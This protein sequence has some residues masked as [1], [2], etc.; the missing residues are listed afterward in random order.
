MLVAS[1]L[2]A[3]G[4]LAGLLASSG[5][6]RHAPA[7]APTASSPSYRTTHVTQPGAT[8]PPPATTRPV[9]TSQPAA[10]APAAVG[11]VAITVADPRGAVPVQLYFPAARAGAA[12]VSPA[13]APYPLIVFSPGYDI[14]PAAYTPLMDAW[15]AARY[16][17]A[18][19]TY[20][21]TAPG[22]PN[23]LDEADIV[24]HPAD[25]H[26]VIDQILALSAAPGGLL[27]GMVDPGRLGVAGHSDG[28]DVTDAVVSNSCCRD[29]RIKAAAVLAG[30]ELTS[31]GGTY[32]APSVPL[33][34]AQGDADPINVPACSE[35]IY[36][37]A[38]APRYYLDLHGAQHHTPYMSAPYSGPPTAA[39]PEYRQAVVTVSVLFWQAYLRQDAAALSQLA[40]WSG[41]GSAATLYAG[42]PVTIGGAC[43]GAPG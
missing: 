25:L 42:A 23:G 27:G 41:A 15:A 43:P 14:D 18:V 37:G 13:G 32:S 8:T 7:P 4:V 33:L 36:D 11:S 26:A 9:A 17:V 31:F 28:G 10:V 16:V 39:A 1:L 34:V 5:P 3:A 2:G 21:G 38:G 12:T 30:A 24:N 29:P 35:Q 20:Q 40:G 22:D 6:G 19:P